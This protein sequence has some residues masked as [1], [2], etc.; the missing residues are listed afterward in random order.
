MPTTTK[1]ILAY[2]ARSQGAEPDW[3][4]WAVQMMMQ[5]H[6]TPH[7]RQLAGADTG[8]D[9]QEF[10]EINERTLTELGLDRSAD[11]NVVKEYAVEVLEK[12]KAGQQQPLEAIWTLEELGSPSQEDFLSPFYNLAYWSSAVKNGEPNYEWGPLT[13]ENMDQFLRNTCLE[14][15]AQFRQDL[16][17]RAP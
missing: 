8:C 1:R 2:R 5:G 13:P 17:N 7:L 3:V 16:S 15:L 10:F 12:V 6:D 9:R 14:G 11:E 4:D